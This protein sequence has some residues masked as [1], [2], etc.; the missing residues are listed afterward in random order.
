MQLNALRA[1]STVKL[2]SPDVLQ[3][4]VAEISFNMTALLRNIST[5]VLS[6]IPQT[7][8]QIPKHL[9]SGAQPLWNPGM[10]RGLLKQSDDSRQSNLS[11]R[12][13]LAWIGKALVAVTGRTPRSV[14][15]CTQTVYLWCVILYEYKNLLYVFI[16]IHL[17]IYQMEPYKS[18]YCS[19]KKWGFCF[20][21]ISYFH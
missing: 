15:S 11:F 20:P 8:S 13:S 12:I 14:W 17:N 19:E 2:C 16:H 9:C 4:Q 10:S 3:W 1:G 21:P 5:C 6:L 7:C 18:L